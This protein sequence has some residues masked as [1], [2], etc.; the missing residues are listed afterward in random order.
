MAE[1]ISLNDKS[2]LNAG[3]S[4]DANKFT[5]EEKKS[6]ISNWNEKPINKANGIKAVNTKDI[7]LRDIKIFTLVTVSI[8]TIIFAYTILKDGTLL[9]NLNCVSSPVDCGNTTFQNGSV[10]CGACNCGNLTCPT[11]EN[12]SYIF[13]QLS[14]LT[15]QVNNLNCS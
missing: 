10:Q 13:T 1:D 3:L 5:K 11:P 2:N 4:L 15:A 14:N 7:W 9:P 6:L 8:A 12:L